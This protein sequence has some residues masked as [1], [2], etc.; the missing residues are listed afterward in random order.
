MS[1]YKNNGS[2]ACVLCVNGRYFHGFTKSGSVQ[3]AWS[4]AGATFFGDYSDDP[5]D[6]IH[7]IIKRLES[8]GYYPVV[9]YVGFVG[10]P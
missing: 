5:S 3:L 6:S 9:R 4:L 1:G 8:K 10:C 7:P 2:V